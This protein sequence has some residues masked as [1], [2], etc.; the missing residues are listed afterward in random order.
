MINALIFAVGFVAQGFFSARMLI[1][2]ILSERQ[3][4]IV[5]PVVYWGCSLVGSILLFVYGLN[6]SEKN[7]LFGKTMKMQ[8]LAVSRN[9]ELFFSL[10]MVWADTEKATLLAKWSLTALPSLSVTTKNL[11]ISEEP[12]NSGGRL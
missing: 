8:P 1:Q 4:R 5:S 2:W 10:Q 3:K 7:V 12:V 11:L 9:S 6:K